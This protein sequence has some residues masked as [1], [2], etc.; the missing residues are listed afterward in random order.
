MVVVA[1]VLEV[2][3]GARQQVGKR[4]E[5][6]LGPHSCPVVLQALDLSAH[7]LHQGYRGVQ[8]QHFQGTTQLAHLGLDFAQADPAAVALEHILEGV[9]DV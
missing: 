5:V 7:L 2:V 4:G 9:T 1:Q 6:Q 8:P 3:L